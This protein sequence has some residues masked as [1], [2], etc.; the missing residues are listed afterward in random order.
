MTAHA[1]A[2]FNGEQ[3][4]PAERLSTA[5]AL[6]EV[7]ASFGKT[8]LDIRYKGLYLGRGIAQH[9]ASVDQL[10]E[11]ELAPSDEPIPHRLAHLY[12]EE[13]VDELEGW[14]DLNEEH[15]T[16]IALE[17]GFLT[18]PGGLVRYR[19]EEVRRRD[20]GRV[21]ERVDVER[22]AA[23]ARVLTRDREVRTLHRE[24][25]R[26]IGN[27]WEAYHRSLVALLH[28]AEHTEADLRDVDGFFLNV[29]HVVIAD[30]RVSNA[31]RRRLVGAANDA[32]DA[33][34]RVFQQKDAVYLPDAIARRIEVE[35]WSKALGD[36]NL[37]V[38]TEMNIGDWMQ[39][40]D[41]WLLTV[42]G[43]LGALRACTLE[44]L[45]DTEEHIARCARG[46]CEVGDA[47]TTALVPTEYVTL[48]PGRERE[49]QKKLDLWDRFMLAEGIGPGA[50]RLA[51]AAT[52][53]GAGFW[54]G[55]VAAVNHSMVVYN[56]LDRAVDVWVGDEVASLGPLQHEE[57]DL[58]DS[59]E[60]DIR[61][62]TREGEEIERFTAD[63]GNTQAQ[64][65]YNVASA[66]PLVEWT[67]VY[68]TGYDPGP[69][70]VGTPRITTTD[71]EY[72]FTEPPSSASGSGSG[73]T[74]LVLDGY[75]DADP[76]SQIGALEGRDTSAL[77]LGHARWD[78]PGSTHLLMWLRLAQDLPEFPEILATRIEQSPDVNLLRLEQ[79]VAV[80]D[81]ARREVCE[82]QRREGRAARGGDA[83]YLEARC[84]HE[85]A[86]RR[87]AYLAGYQQ[88]PSNPFFARAAGSHLAAWGRYDEAAQA[89]ETARRS[90]NDLAAEVSIELAR[91]RRAIARPNPAT[92]HDL[93]SYSSR[94]QQ[95]QGIEE[96]AEWTQEGL[97]RSFTLLADGLYDDAV[98]HA[99]GVDP[100]VADAL[101]RLAAASEGARPELIERAHA[102]APTAGIDY[103]TVWSAV[104]LAMRD[105]RDATALVAK[106]TELVGEERVTLMLGWADPFRL[107]E[108]V[109][110]LEEAL[111]Y[112]DVEMRGQAR[113]MGVITLGPDAPEAWKDEAQALLFAVERP[114]LSPPTNGRGA[115]TGNVLGD[116]SVERIRDALEALQQQ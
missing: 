17:E 74:K 110:A 109:E 94:L 27:G 58:E 89:L 7:D 64:Y 114:R 2:V 35:S 66:S 34:A 70:Q 104:A 81:A 65:V 93:L 113:V 112:L 86:A 25:A 19:G 97:G 38:P 1:L 51:V 69:R 103:Q 108:E 99:Y 24:A 84:A 79:D 21:I 50:L 42:A 106:A 44:V 116:D 82:R 76:M 8:Y 26:Q 5:D 85:A 31:E 29:F 80:D 83:E 54:L 101:L 91:V 73:T 45:L 78:A 10:F 16:L 15:A 9:G 4:L 62:L 107:R 102:L 46:E 22:D 55:G 75:R 43:D 67:A 12:P 77:V 6:D 33:L 111:S 61:A 48:L 96:R 63:I 88:F 105:G 100:S 87:D 68:G 32:Y 59:D 11:A 72:L 41:S 30:G 28:Y 57:V 95:L 52:I 71:A 13:L 40:A 98:N 37:G 92:M 53:L 56:G 20:L 36:F 3:P 47:P 23:L 18:A 14:L 49:R 90:R 60:V 39:A 115:V